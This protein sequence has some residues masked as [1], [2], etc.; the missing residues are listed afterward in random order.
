MSSLLN[1]FRF[2]RA[3]TP[4]AKSCLKLA[5]FRLSEGLLVRDIHSLELHSPL[6]Q[7][8]PWMEYIV[9]FGW[10]PNLKRW[11]LFKMANCECLSRSTGVPRTHNIAIIVILYV[12]KL[13]LCPLKTSKNLRVNWNC[14]F[15]IL[16]SLSFIAYGV[17]QFT[18]QI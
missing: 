16:F 8:F 17:L 1:L 9:R 5:T 11:A 15:S 6:S 13:W 4:N 10:A 3:G 14:Y 18:I 2:P 7:A 12:W